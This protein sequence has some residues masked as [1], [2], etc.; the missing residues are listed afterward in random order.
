MEIAN[1]TIQKPDFVSKSYKEYLK[2]KEE[3][4]EVQNETNKSNN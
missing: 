2:W 3:K 4:K 1:K